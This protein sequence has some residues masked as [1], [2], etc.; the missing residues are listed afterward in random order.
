MKTTYAYIASR[1]PGP[2]AGIAVCRYDAAGKLQYLRT[3]HEGLGLHIGSLLINRKQGILYC[4][5]ETTA[6]PGCR[7]GG[8]RILAFRIGDD[9]G[10]SLISESPSFGAKPAF[11]QADDEYQYLLCVNHGGREKVTETFQDDTGAYRIRTRW[12]ESNLVLFPLNQD[13]SICPPV[14]ICRL[15]GEGPRHFQAGPH[16]HSVVKA[17][18]RNLYLV[19]DKGGDRVYTF[20][21]DCKSEKIMPC[22]A[23]SC[24]PGAA[25]RYSAFH[26]SLP[27]VYANMEAE[28]LLLA[29]RYSE[30]GDLKLLQETD[31]TPAMRVAP[32]EDALMQSDLCVSP[33][34]CLYEML[35]V[36]NVIE[37]YAADS[38]TGTLSLRQT[39]ETPPD[40]RCLAMTPDGRYL[41][42]AYAAAGRAEL[43]PLRDDGTLRPAQSQV[44][45]PAA[46]CI[47]F[48][49]QNN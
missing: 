10:L 7:G 5:D 14:D 18:G 22:A 36:Y 20:R 27:M 21:I 4:T 42:A 13:G 8:G 49:S 37:V 12:D 35:R 29:F 16:A 9:G 34:G 30:N 40:G 38:Q 15:H 39:I 33:A 47:A 2:G 26:P 19:C 24:P 3:E 43:Y 41:A 48:Y 23:V 28:R 44:E 46:A 32:P 11:L 25:P 1:T 31:T 45:L 17:P 6:L